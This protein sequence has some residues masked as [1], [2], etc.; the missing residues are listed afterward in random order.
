MLDQVC[1][2]EVVR[3]KFSAERHRQIIANQIAALAS[4]GSSR[5]RRGGNELV[6]YPGHTWLG[7][8]A[9]DESQR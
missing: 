9:I 4:A 5:V 3:Y 7:C 1:L 8:E 2:Q 6:S